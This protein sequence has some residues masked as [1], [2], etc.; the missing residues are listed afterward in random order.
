MITKNGFPKGPRNNMTE[1][2]RFWEKVLKLEG[3]WEWRGTIMKAR[4]YGVF[5]AFDKKLGKKAAILAHRY[6][7]LLHFKEI[8]DDLYV[9]HKCDNRKCV[10]PDHLFLGTQKVNMHDMIAKG[11]HMEVT[12]PHTH[13]RGS[14]VWNSVFTEDQV[15]RM[16]RLALKGVSAARMARW[17]DRDASGISD[18][19]CGESW[20]HVPFP[21]EVTDTL[22]LCSY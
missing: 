11:R 16:R 6:S 21:T 18:L 17:L 15:F 5:F 14:K 10:R 8:P 3:C 9:L 7:Y 12:K 4:G 20:A 2:E 19:L 1:L 13:V 22:E